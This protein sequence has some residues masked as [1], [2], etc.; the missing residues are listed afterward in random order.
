MASATKYVEGEY[1]YCSYVSQRSPNQMYDRIAAVAT[2]TIICTAIGAGVGSAAGGIGAGPGAGIG[3]G[4]GLGVG[5]GIV[6]AWEASDYLK[7]KKTLTK[8]G[9]DILIQK[10]GANTRI[11]KECPLT[12]NAMFEQPVVLHTCPSETF[13][14][15]A[16]EKYIE[17]HG[18]C[19]ITGMPVKESD[20][21]EDISIYALMIQNCKSITESSLKSEGYSDE[22]IRGINLFEQHCI[23][24]K[25]QFVKNETTFLLSAVHDG[26][27]ETDDVISKLKEMS[28]AEK[29]ER[30][31]TIN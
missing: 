3:F 21:K 27:L 1:T 22:Q 23:E 2:T 19:P 15:K 7:H 11:K 5:V 16:L 30:W 24:K 18:K 12:K 9:R 28:L 13:E 10:Y 6:A 17:K 4:V 26:K 29:G 20:I 14:K 8:T 25:A 31:K